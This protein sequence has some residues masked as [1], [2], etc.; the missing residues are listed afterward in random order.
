[1]NK[2]TKQMR[3]QLADA[4]RSGV[5]SVAFPVPVFNYHSYDKSEMTTRTLTNSFANKDGVVSTSPARNMQM[6]VLCNAGGGANACLTVHEP[7][8]PNKPVIFKNH[9]SYGDN[10][11]DYK[12]PLAMRGQAGN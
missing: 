2:N 12:Q 10:F 6:R 8:D 4:R 11:P 7:I 9:K 5:H 3:V 1:M